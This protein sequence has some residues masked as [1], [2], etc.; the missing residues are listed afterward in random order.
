M[1]KIMVLRGF[2]LIEL[3]YV[4]GTLTFFGAVLALIAFIVYRWV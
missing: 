3:L 2:T 1:K 4:G